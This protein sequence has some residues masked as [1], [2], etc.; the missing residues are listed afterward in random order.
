MRRHVLSKDLRE[1]LQFLD[2]RG[3]EYLVCGGHAVA[4]HGY[5]RLTTDLDI[6]VR[7]SPENADRVMAALADFGFGDAGLTADVFTHRG[8]A[9]TLGVQPNQVDL[10]TSMGRSDDESVFAAAVPGEIDGIT[11]RYVSLEDLLRAKREAG[12]AKDLADVEELTRF[13]GRRP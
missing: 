8:T 13:H 7:P 6:L 4:F 12:R 5:P 11:V 3:V 2:R 9:V 1:F 10:L